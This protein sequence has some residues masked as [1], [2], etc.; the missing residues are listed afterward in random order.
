MRGKK[1]AFYVT[2]FTVLQKHCQNPSGMACHPKCEELLY[3]Y[4]QIYRKGMEEM[5]R[6][7]MCIFYGF[8]VALRMN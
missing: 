2:W 1:P 3:R 5:A 4:F 8:L 6:K 7:N